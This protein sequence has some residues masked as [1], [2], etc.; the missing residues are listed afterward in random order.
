MLS[1][2]TGLVFPIIV[3]LQLSNEEQVAVRNTRPVDWVDIAPVEST[4][5][6]PQG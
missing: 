6:I 2:I 5:I 3:T 1:G 4:A